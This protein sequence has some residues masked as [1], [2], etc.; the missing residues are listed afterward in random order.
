MHRA[1]VDETDTVENAKSFG[2]EI[3]RRKVR[4]VANLLSN[5]SN[6]GKK[7]PR[8]VVTQYLYLL[9]IRIVKIKKFFAKI[10][11]I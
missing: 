1:R 10:F 7:L 4:F 6:L 3:G 8:K 9:D 2:V 5:L 11:D